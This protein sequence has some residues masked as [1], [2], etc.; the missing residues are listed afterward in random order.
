MCHQSVGL[1]AR[2]VEA[3]G[4]PTLCMTSALDITQA[5]NPPRAVF[6]N[7]PL[8]HQTGKPDDRE[9]QRAIVGDALRAFETMNKPGT[10]VEL[11]Y[12]WDANDR[13]WEE[14]DYT[15]GFMPARPK[16]AAAD[17][18]EQERRRRYTTANPG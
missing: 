8:G 4:I 15:P 13:R 1:I 3:A 6:L 18:A 12:V 10:I 16:K 7:Y 11:P 9:N 2:E 17:L 5:V 14:T